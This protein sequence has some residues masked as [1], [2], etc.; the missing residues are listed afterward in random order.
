MAVYGRQVEPFMRFDKL[1]RR[2]V[3]AGRKGNSEIVI[4]RDVA[5]C[6]GGQAASNQQV[7]FARVGRDGRAAFDRSEFHVSVPL[8]RAAPSLP[9]NQ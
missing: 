3:A 5:L 8:F 6:G 4:G 2:A 7:G 9:S 1:A